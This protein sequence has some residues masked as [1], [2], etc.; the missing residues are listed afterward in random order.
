MIFSPIWLTNIVVDLVMQP[1]LVLIKSF[2]QVKDVISYVKM[3]LGLSPP[4]QQDII[5]GEVRAGQEIISTRLADLVVG[6]AFGAW[7]PLLLLLH[8]LLTPLMLIALELKSKE[9][10]RRN[11]NELFSINLVSRIMASVCA[12]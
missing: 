11:W 10:S 3:R 2:A 9:C 4:T 5:F 1:A 12:P 7:S 6:C 8:S